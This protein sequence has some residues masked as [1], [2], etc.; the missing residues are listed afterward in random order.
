MK[1]LNVKAIGKLLLEALVVLLAM[2][3][4]GVGIAS[5]A[6]SLYFK[7]VKYAVWGGLI[8]IVCWAAATWATNKLGETLKKERLYYHREGDE[9]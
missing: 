9:M 5:F 7:N 4:G 3:I 2:M 1:N 8:A 6:L